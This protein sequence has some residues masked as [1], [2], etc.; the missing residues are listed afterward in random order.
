[1][2]VMRTSFVGF[3]LLGVLDLS[4]SLTVFFFQRQHTELYAATH[5][6]SKQVTVGI[7]P[8][9]GFEYLFGNMNS[10]R[11][12]AVITQMKNAGVQWVRLDYYPND[13]F[14]YQFIK[15]AESA[16][17]N[18]DI[19]LE[20]FTATPREYAN[21]CR[22][23]VARLKP[24][25]VHTYE[26]LNEVNTYTPTITAAQYTSILKSV[27]PAIK[28]ADPLSTV[29][30]SGLG[31]G[32]GSQ[33]PYTYLQNMYVA[34]AKGY[35]DAANMHPYSFPNMPAPPNA[36]ACHNYNAFCYDL[37]ALH[38][39]MEQNG[40]GNKKIWLTEFGCPT[41]SD[42]GQPAKCTDA[43]LAQQITQA[44]NRA[45]T[46]RWTGPFFVFSWQD[47]TTDGDFGLYY[48]NGSPKTTALAAYKQAALRYQRPS[49]L[50]GLPV[51]MSGLI[52]NANAMEYCRWIRSGGWRSIRWQIDKRRPWSVGFVS[53]EGLVISWN[54]AGEDAFGAQEGGSEAGC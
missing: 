16:D 23:A 31:I 49:P 53:I 4:L 11:Q 43:T 40:D 19:L 8:G 54:R 22:Q 47:N 5:S 18:V 41:G 25:G 33:E 39:V 28:D 2:S 29:L 1:M 7:S 42:A 51:W 27:Y 48:A 50:R 38:A 36:S 30:M 34:G 20:D 35:F 14:D 9:F 6:M 45:N 17:I 37:P 13:S 46:W 26:I 21:F 10:N 3:L 44:F 52:G 24:L 32:P 12:Q 15:D